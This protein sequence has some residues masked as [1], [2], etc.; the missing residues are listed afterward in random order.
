MHNLHLC[1]TDISDTECPAHRRIVTLTKYAAELDDSFL[2]R[3]RREIWRH[4][5]DPTLLIELNLENAPIAVGFLRPTC[6]GPG[7]PH[8]KPGWLRKNCRY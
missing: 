5:F 1:S 4:P 6:F 7:E 2:S 3:V 8:G